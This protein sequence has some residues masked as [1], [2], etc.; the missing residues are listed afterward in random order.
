MFYETWF[1]TDHDQF[2]FLKHTLAG[3]CWPDPKFTF[4][5]VERAIQRESET[6]GYLARYGLRA[7]VAA[8]SHDMEMLQR[9]E[10]KYR[11]AT[12]RWPADGEQPMTQYPDRSE[13]GVIRTVP[14]QASL[15]ELG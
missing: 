2:R 7:E 5:D 13:L 14:M 4:S 1:K 11:P 10:T 15:F 6:R 12:S 8:H 3:R 9:L